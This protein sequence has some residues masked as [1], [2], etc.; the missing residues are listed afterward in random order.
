MS[1]PAES[2]GNEAV[3]AP[4][5]PESPGEDAPNSRQRKFLLS[6]TTERVQIANAQRRKG[7]RLW[8]RL[9]LGIS[10]TL[11]FTTLWAAWYVYTRG[12]TKKWRTYLSQ[13]LRRYGLDVTVQ[14]LT[15]D[16]FEGLV[17]RNVTLSRADQPAAGSLFITRAAVDVRLADLF[18]SQPFLNSV[19]LRDAR[20]SLPVDASDPQSPRYEI[21]RLRARFLFLPGQVRLAQ[22][23]GDCEGIRFSARGTVEAKDLSVLRVGD[24]PAA[25]ALAA[26]RRLARRVLEEL[27]ALKFSGGTPRLEVEFGG[28][29]AKPETLTASATFRCDGVQHGRYALR[30]FQLSARYGNGLFQVEQ[31][32]AADARGKL[33]AQAEFRLATGM[34]SGEVR[35]DLDLAAL[36]TEFWPAGLEY[37]L[38]AGEPPKL[39][40][41]F[42]FRVPGAHRGGGNAPASAEPDLEL[43]GKIDARMLVMRGAAFDRLSSEFSWRDGSWYLRSLRLAHR[44]GELKGDLMQSPTECRAQVVSTLD[45]DVLAPL[46][47]REGRAVVGELAFQDPPRIEFTAEGRSFLNPLTLTAK[48]RFDLKRSRFRG[49]SAT[50]ASGEWDFRQLT[51]SVRKLAIERPEG[52]ASADAII[53]EVLRRELHFENTRV[54]LWPAEAMR[55]IDP[56]WVRFAQPYRFR[57]PP[58]ILVTGMAGLKGG[59]DT[60]L[61]LDI[62]AA[63]GLD[64]QLPKRQIP[65]TKLRTRLTFHDKSLELRDMQAEGF[66]G[67]WIG[68]ADVHYEKKGDPP[69]FRGRL[70]GQDTDFPAL[71]KHWLDFSETKGRFGG[72]VEF[73]GVGTDVTRFAGKGSLRVD[74]NVLAIPVF[75]PLSVLLGKAVPGL[76]YQPAREGTADFTIGGGR[77]AT[78]NFLIRG[79]GFALIGRGWVSIMGDD[80]MNFRMRSNAQGA[81]GAIAYPLSALSQFQTEG[82]LSAPVWQLSA[83]AAPPPAAPVPAKAKAKPTAP[84]KK[85]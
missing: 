14:K 67:K 55:W 2:E 6:S 79:G 34:A 75:G 62:D 19:D 25:Q 57:K 1:S 36:F 84:A 53:W 80:R 37:G 29:A 45:P 60:D 8:F 21:R 74:G 43:T 3:I 4:P 56:D 5:R 9:T 59:P 17:A 40:T 35:S 12:F 82:P 31:L 64:V 72:R 24:P 51:L 44:S 20:A 30:A 69:E 83:L 15:L 7:R 76:G 16:P 61:H 13:E 85:P 38:Q 71:T 65:V 32:T 48:G 68:E 22:A 26:R 70:E 66:G 47:P 33:R 28:D 58:D 23:E 46:L 18:R 11:L 81:I 39:E 10:L 49:V 50:R 52:N 42:R 63:G 77:M 78:D 27:R 73:S 41:S 54:R